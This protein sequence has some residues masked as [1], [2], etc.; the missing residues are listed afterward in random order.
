VSQFE[1]IDIKLASVGIAFGGIVSACA[2]VMAP[3]AT[4]YVTLGVMLQLGALVSRPTSDQ[5]SFVLAFFGSLREGVH[6]G[7]GSRSVLL[8]VFV[9]GFLGRGVEWLHHALCNEVPLGWLLRIIPR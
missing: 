2:M 7:S 1:D 5:S 6:R 8:V 4:A 9:G 3:N